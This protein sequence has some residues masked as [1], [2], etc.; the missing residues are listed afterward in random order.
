MIIIIVA[1]VIGYIALLYC[2]YLV[3]VHFV[4]KRMEVIE[5]EVKLSE[6][7]AAKEAR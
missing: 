2:C 6:K 4:R 5:L 3:R 7:E 1:S